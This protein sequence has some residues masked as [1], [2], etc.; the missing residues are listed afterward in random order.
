MDSYVLE[1][2]SEYINN[3][4]N[5][6]ILL[7][8]ANL[9]FPSIL[10]LTKLPLDYNAAEGYKNN[11]IF[12]AC[13]ELNSIENYGE[14]IINSL[15]NTS[16]KYCVS[17]DPLSGTQA[18]YAIYNAILEPGDVVLSLAQS[19]GGHSSHY[20]YLKKNYILKEYNYNEQEKDID[21]KQISN[22]CDEFHPK[23]VIAGAS[24]FPL[25]IKYN[26]LSDICKQSNS[27]LLADISHMVI[28]IM[29][30]LHSNPFHYADFITFTTHKTTRGPRGAILAC[31]EK[32]ISQINASIF[33][34]TQG[35]PIY[36]QICA[37]VLMLEE[38]Q[39]NDLL[40]YSKRILLLSNKFMEYCRLQNIPLWI[41]HT[42][43]HI[44][45]LDTTNLLI[46]ASTVQKRLEKN[47][48]LVTSCLLPNDKNIPHG[49]RFGFM[50]LATLGI[51][52]KDF[53]SLLDYIIKNITNEDVCCKEQIEELMKPYYERF[54]QEGGIQ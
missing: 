18:N 7:G 46:N 45:V 42:D 13:D 29:S 33:P 23:L 36:S 10:G 22:L 17:F 51:N 28:Y 27:L 39:R 38:L 30:G 35:A 1:K 48:I 24:S 14:D 47:N 25:A 4:Y 41:S 5:S 44:C 6:A 40:E 15:F 20:D 2:I 8:S 53:N 49:I 32:F 26:V 3:S 16:E 11:R 52:L 21:Y 9:P 12:P 50:M 19:S 37:K 31:K 34:L 43:S 54:F